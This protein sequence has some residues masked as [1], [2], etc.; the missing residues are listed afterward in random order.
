MKKEVLFDKENNCHTCKHGYFEEFLETHTLC[1][2]HN[3]YLCNMQR[4]RCEDYE[5]GE[6]PKGK[7]SLR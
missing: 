4:G 7:K 2:K 5:K 6:I 1:G 3:C